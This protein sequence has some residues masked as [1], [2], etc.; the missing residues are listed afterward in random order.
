MHIAFDPAK[1]ALAPYPWLKELKNDDRKVTMIN[2][3]N[4]LN[5]TL[6][7]QIN[8]MKNRNFF[9]AAIIHTVVDNFIKSGIKPKQIGVVT[10]SVDQQALLQK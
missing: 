7:K 4:L 8:S 9:E 2:T 3:D 6:Q 10:T 1:D 5:K